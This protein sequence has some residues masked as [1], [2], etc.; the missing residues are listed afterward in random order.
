MKTSIREK[1]AWVLSSLGVA[2]LLAVA[3]FGHSPAKNP[4]TQSQREDS[5]QLVQQI[6]QELHSAREQISKV[7]RDSAGHKDKL[8][9]L[10]DEAERESQQLASSLPRKR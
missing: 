6:S 4:A 8:E 7:D 3:A 9:Q 10:L 1:S 5:E 2:L